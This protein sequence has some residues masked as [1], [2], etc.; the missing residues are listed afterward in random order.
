[1]IGNRTEPITGQVFDNKH[2]PSFRLRD[3][4]RLLSSSMLKKLTNKHR[5][6]DQTIIGNRTDPIMHDRNTEDIPDKK[7]GKKVC[8][9]VVFDFKVSKTS[10]PKLLKLVM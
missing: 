1:M 7:T 2:I 8:A 6:I 10:K 9:S 4:I 3:D 5:L